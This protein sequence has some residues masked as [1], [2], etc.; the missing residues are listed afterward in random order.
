MKKVIIAFLVTAL[1]FSVFIAY[2]REMLSRITSSTWQEF[3]LA[4]DRLIRVAAP[5]Q[6]G[7]A[8]SPHGSGAPPQIEEE[9]I[10]QQVKEFLT[11]VV[12]GSKVL[13]GMRTISSLSLTLDNEMGRLG[14]DAAELSLNKKGGELIERLE[15]IRDNVSKL[16]EVSGSIAASS[17]GLNADFPFERSSYLQFHVLLENLEKSLGAAITWLR[18]PRPRHIMVLLQNSS[19]LRATG[20]FVGSVLEV[21]LSGGSVEQV[22]FRDINEIDR[23]SGVIVVPPRPL[24]GIITKWGVADANWFFNFPDSAKKTI[25]LAEKSALYRK[26]NVTFDG[27]VAVSTNVARDLLSI[28]GPVELPEFKLTLDE[29]N[30]VEEVQRDVQLR[31]EKKS[32]QPKR[33]VAAAATETIEKLQTLDAQKKRLLG[34]QLRQW[35]ID[36]DVM[37]YLKDEALQRSLEAYGVAGNVLELPGSFNGDY[38]AIVASNVGGGKTDSVMKQSVFF[39]SQ[40]NDDGTASDHLVIE[41]R[42]E[43]K[44]GDAWWYRVPNETY[45]RVFVP[46]SAG[47]SNFIGGYDKRIAQRVNYRT[48]GYT[49]DVLIT[50]IEGSVKDLVGF[51]ALNIFEEA[52]KRVFAA[53]SRV[54]PGSSGKITFDY[55]HRL[56]LTPAPGERYQ[57]VFEKQPGSET[58]YSFEISAP[59]G[60][61]WR[62][63]SSPLFEYKTSS[64]PGRLIINLTLEKIK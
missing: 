1:A 41:R 62:E 60:F 55:A 4:T 26:D 6:T 23:G 27:V 28:V 52:G 7:D 44:T 31:E 2:G 10:G 21:T 39:Q 58:D 22:T 11:L 15:H 46:P 17:E 47:I 8:V 25:E 24:Q 37:V 19:E 61:R 59:I 64:P 45:L 18:S 50:A 43:G 35:I 40:L 51:P 3:Q 49:P 42:H 36:K 14:R 30:V 57:L 54:L 20:G 12:S 38:L 33:L 53:W 13:S 16:K 63:N 34:E 56:F 32:A 29:R 5:G 9:S 48:A